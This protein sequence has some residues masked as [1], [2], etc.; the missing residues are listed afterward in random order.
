MKFLS[1]FLR[2]RVSNSRSVRTPKDIA[3]KMQEVDIH[4]LRVPV[5]FANKV[6]AIRSVSPSTS[7]EG[8]AAQVP[9]GLQAST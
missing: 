3:I 5:A 4:T 2:I 8:N 1:K 6:K 9:K 7:S